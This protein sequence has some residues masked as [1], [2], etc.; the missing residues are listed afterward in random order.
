MKD[1]IVRGVV[2]YGGK[3]RGRVY[4]ALFTRNPGPPAYEAQLDAPGPFEIHGVAPG[5]Y[6]P[7]A[8]LSDKPCP[9]DAPPASFADAQHDGGRPVNVRDG[10]VADGIRLAL[11][12]KPRES[13]SAF[14]EGKRVEFG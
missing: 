6:F 7:Q 8:C 9:P 12:D 1:S 10:Q 5:E 14:V 11:E 13:A 4:I 3:R 2:T